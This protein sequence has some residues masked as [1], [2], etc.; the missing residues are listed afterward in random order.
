MVLNRDEVREL[1]RRTA[2]F[3][4]LA[5]SL[6]GPLG[7]GRWRRETIRSLGLRPGD[8]VVDLCCGTGANFAALADAVGETGRVVGVDLSAAMLRRARARVDRGGWTNVA[9]VQADVLDYPLPQNANA[10]V[11]TFGLEMVPEYDAVVERIGAA[12]PR[13]GRLALMGLKHPDG[14]P[15]WLVDLGIALNRP[16]GVDRS[17][18]QHQPWLSVRSHMNELEHREFLFGAVYR[19][20]GHPRDGHSP[21]PA[22]VENPGMS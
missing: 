10:V 9:M 12:L 11:S 5:L 17:Y 6:A 1:Y 21:H 20:V 15:D 7:V 3:Y 13:S 14:W 22:L 18:E 19:S 4:D 8:T 2:R 16:F